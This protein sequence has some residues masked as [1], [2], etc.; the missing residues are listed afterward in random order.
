MLKNAQ[1][2]PARVSRYLE[3]Q[4]YNKAE[5]A[6]KIGVSPDGFYAM[7]SNRKVMTADIFANLCVA[8]GVSAERLATYGEPKA[9]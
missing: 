8:L 9:M 5:I 6:R 4:G 2:V 7:L 3:D 1:S